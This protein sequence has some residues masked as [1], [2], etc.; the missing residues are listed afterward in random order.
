MS[1]G[2]SMSLSTDRDVDRELDVI[3]NL[4]WCRQGARCHYQPMVMSTGS[5]M[6]L[7]TD[8]DVDRELDVIINRWWCRQGA[9]CHYQPIVMWTG[10]SMSLST[11]SDVMTLSS[12]STYLSV[13]HDIKLPIDITIGWFDIELPV[14]VMSM[15][16]LM[17]WSTDRYVDGE[18][19]VM[20]NR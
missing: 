9:R 1:T 6:S 11:D 5:S 10:S 17:S 18:L 7:S 13:D 12:P 4:W 14:I 16:S 8:G 2:S 3:I 15:G 20:I 19:N